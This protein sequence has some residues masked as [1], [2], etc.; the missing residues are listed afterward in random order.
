M[1]PLS[2]ALGTN[3]F[4][5][6]GPLLARFTGLRALALPVEAH[7]QLPALWTGGELELKLDRRFLN[8]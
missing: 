8:R 5:S 7:C 4:V 6:H 2:L 3:C 1:C